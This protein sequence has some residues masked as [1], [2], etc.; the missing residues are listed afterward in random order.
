M[1]EDKQLLKLMRSGD[2]D[3]LRQIYEKYRDDMFTVALSL[4]RD[5]HASEDCLQDVFVRFAGGVADLKIRRNLKSYLISCVAN[6]ARDR[7]RK[8]TIQLDCPLEELSSLAISS[9]P[10]SNIIDCEELRRV[11]L[12]MA[13][14][15]CA[16]REV[17]V[18]RVQG[19]LKFR[20]IARIQNVSIKTVQGRYRYGI[21]KLR[22]LLDK[23]N[24]HEISA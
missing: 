2:T 10:A 12:A 5:I 6:R 11:F 7:L 24:K 20:E 9:D 19:G 14:L 18:L 3:A 17:F 4:L 21:E 8:K 22:K 23:E 16:Q 13:E 15:P 1:S